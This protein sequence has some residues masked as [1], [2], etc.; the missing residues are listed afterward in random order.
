MTGLPVKIVSCSPL[1]RLTFESHPFRSENTSGCSQLSYASPP[2]SQDNDTGIE[3]ASYKSVSQ[4]RQPPVSSTEFPVLLATSI[5]SPVPRA[6][7][8]SFAMFTRLPNRQF[9]V[10][11][12]ANVLSPL[13]TFTGESTNPFQRYV[14][15]MSAR[16]TALSFA[17]LTFSCAHLEACGVQN[18]EKSLDFYTHALAEIQRCINEGTTDDQIVTAIVILVYYEIVSYMSFLPKEMLSRPSS[19]TVAIRASSRAISEEL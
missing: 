7:T 2:T 13:I 4:F 18:T 17:I 16:S 11:H 15:P 19:F 1:Q 5:G 8:S 10:A 12:F 3:D 6:A 9:L 14:L